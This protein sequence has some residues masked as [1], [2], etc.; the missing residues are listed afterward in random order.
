MIDY[1]SR[2]IMENPF[3]GLSLDERRRMMIYYTVVREPVLTAEEVKSRWNVELAADEQLP[4]FKVAEIAE[5]IRAE[6]N[7]RSRRALR[8][9]SWCIVMGVVSVALL[10]AFLMTYGSLQQCVSERDAAQT[11]C[12]KVKVECAKRLEDACK[13]NEVQREEVRR[14]YDDRIK[15]IKDEHS[16]MLRGVN[17]KHKVEIATL[18]ESHNKEI[19]SI[20]KKTRDDTLQSI[21]GKIDSNLT[22]NAK[23]EI[24]DRKA[25]AQIKDLLWPLP[26]KEDS[27]VNLCEEAER[28]LEQAK[29]EF[30]KEDAQNLFRTATN[31]EAFLTKYVKK[32][33]RSSADVVG[34]DMRLDLENSM[35][36]CY[37]KAAVKIPQASF[38][39]A[40]LYGAQSFCK[41]G[42]YEGYILSENLSVARSHLL[43]AC[44]RKDLDALRLEFAVLS[45][46]S[47]DDRYWHHD[48]RNEREGIDEYAKHD[49]MD[50][51]FWPAC[52]SAGAAIAV[53]DKTTGDDIC[54]V[55]Q[56][57]DEYSK[58]I[59]DSRL[60]RE[61]IQPTSYFKLAAR[62]GNAEAKQWLLERGLDY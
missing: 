60:L 20:A 35:L 46:D 38:R 37:T 48:F 53:N 13:I 43:E 34:T 12:A 58:A 41:S 42:S 57:I 14:S 4:V 16:D 31:I 6:I 49:L 1:E 21:K 22:A 11:T 56:W 17:E 61:D 9:K 44:R 3:D 25:V 8:L 33:D 45:Q 59:N 7:V 29:H 23:G 18:Q 50:I 54:K 52:V 39:M 24:S 2:S 30:D 10:V 5:E 15:R 51:P 40:M 26:Q 47:E 19:E 55:A 32:S 28:L 36:R 62:K 27:R